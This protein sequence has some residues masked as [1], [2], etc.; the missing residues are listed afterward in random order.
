MA[1]SQRSIQWRADI[2]PWRWLILGSLGALASHCGGKAGD[3]DGPVLLSRGGSGGA[4]ATAGRGG[5]AG[6][7][8]GGTIAGGGYG[9]TTASG[10]YGAAD[11]FPLSLRCQAP[12]TSLGGGW[13]RCANG[14]I[15]RSER[16]VCPSPLPRP[17]ASEDAGSDAA[18][19]A[20]SDGVSD[21]IAPPNDGTCRNDSD[22]TQAAHGHCETPPGGFSSYCQYGCVRDSEC[23][24]GQ[25]CLCGDVVGECVLAT[26]TAD[27]D[28]GS[29]LCVNYTESPGCGSTAFACQSPLDQ[30]ASDAQCSSGAPYCT[31]AGLYGE[32]GRKCVAP[33]CVIGRPFLVDGEERLAACSERSDW[34]PKGEPPATATPADL[35]RELRAALLEGWTAQ[36][37]MEHASVAAFARFALQLASLGAPPELLARTATAML[38][39]IGHA[40]ACF[41]LARRYSERELGPGPLP[42]TG[43]LQ[44]ADLASIVSDSILEGCIG[45]TVAAIEA[46]EALSHCEDPV[47][48][49]LLERIVA[50]ESQHAELA[51]QFLAWALKT[52]PASVRERARAVFRGELE[53]P[54]A[55]LATSEHDQQLLRH[56]LMSSPLRQAL[57]A[58]VLREVIAPCAE[59]LLAPS[60]A[61]AQPPACA[62]PC[63]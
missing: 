55:A 26:C 32:L 51:W 39:E 52:G 23:Q 36:A 56:G 14:M 25:A 45:E 42:V 54:L 19:D 27:S 6:G 49:A 43:A 28:C 3:D 62:A 11:N 31:V 58:R 9:G 7:G 35:P 29:G 34:Y 4:T 15:H 37:L 20:G 63:A 60:G 12:T 50:E 47:V 2:E 40:R 41:A 8:Y 59:A 5:R 38:D 57:R 22:C 61:A 18:S 13:E 16:G 17:S 1:K 33:S 46:A 44:E 30:C 53:R 10:G 48:R 21:L 24:T